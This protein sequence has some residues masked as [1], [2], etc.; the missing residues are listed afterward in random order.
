MEG[1]KLDGRS[2]SLVFRNWYDFLNTKD[3]MKGS[4]TI[5]GDGKQIAKGTLPPLDL[6]YRESRTLPL[7]WP[8]IT[9]EPGVE[10]FLNLN[11]TL[12]HDTPWAKAGYPLAWEQ[13]K[14]PAEAPRKE[15]TAQGKLATTNDAN[16]VRVAGAGFNLSFSKAKGTLQSF[17]YKGVELIKDPLRPHFW[18]APTDNDRG[19]Q[20]DKVLGVWKTAAVT[21]E[22]ITAENLGGGRGSCADPGPAYRRTGGRGGAI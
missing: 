5:T 10:Y 22:E 17:T 6:G 3:A 2:V 11:F 8:A 15:A 12:A 16:A 20:M 7:T 18:R 4:F 19:F 21:S 13:F 14:L 9:P 1:R